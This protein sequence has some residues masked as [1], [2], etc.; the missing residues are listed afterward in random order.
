M[1]EQRISEIWVTF[2]GVLETQIVRNAFDLF[3][4]AHLDR[5]ERVHL[6][7][8]SPGGGI[9]EGVALYNYFRALPMEIIA[10]NFSS[11]SSA[12]V[13]AY[14]GANKRIVTPSATFMVHKTV[15][16]VPNIANERRLKAAS[17]SVGIDDGRV[18]SILREHATLTPEQWAIHGM[19]DLTLTADESIKCGI[20][21]EVGYFCP[22]G[23]LFNF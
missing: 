8:H 22:K 16:P 17:D 1:D 18:E 19:A 14:L 10:Y 23:P 2:A 13:L 11:V 15:V 4:K 3:Q 20:A 6:L 7:I 5:V 9:A 21:H 12:A